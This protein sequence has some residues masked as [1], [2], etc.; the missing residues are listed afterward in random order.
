[1]G[2]LRI[3][4][5]KYRGRVLSA[6][7]GSTTRPLLTRL[8]KSLADVLRPDLPGMV[9]LEMFGGSG[10]I[11]FELISNGAERA[12]IFELDG[13]SA[14]HIREN[15]TKLAAPVRVENGDCLEKLPDLKKR[16]EVFDLIMV[17][18]PYGKGLQEKSMEWLA[19]FPVMKPGSLVIVQREDKEPFWEAARGFTHDQ[20][21]EYG[22]TVFDF[23][24][25]KGR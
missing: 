17:A 13:V 7:E 19:S 3:T 10:A 18:P 22:R 23:Y 1:M 20:T 12:L 9:I 14:R 24:V 16:G 2:D 11:S 25:W 5:G 15:A 21:R 6:P 8:R 4:S